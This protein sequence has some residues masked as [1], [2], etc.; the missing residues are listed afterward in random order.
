MAVIDS[1]YQYYLSTYANTAAC[2]YD[3]HKKSQLRDI[4]NQII[5][6]NKDSPLYKIENTK[7]VT[8]YAIDIKESV[9][10]LQNV[11][12]SLSDTNEG[13]ETI[14]S[15]RIAQSSDENMVSVEY[16]GE[17]AENANGFKIQVE[18]LASNQVNCGNYLNPERLDME[19]G[20]YSFH[21]NTASNCY[22]FQYT[23]TDSD[24]NLSILQKLAKL[25]HSA[26]ID[27]TAAINRNESGQTALTLASKQT[28]AGE[29]QAHIFEILPTPDTASIKA[30]E[31]LGIQSVTRKAQN[32]RFLL[33]GKEH[34]SF[35]NT[36]TVDNNF[37]I[38]LHACSED[39]KSIEIGFKT[40]ID[41]IADNLQK[42]A[43]TYNHI[44]D[45]A[46]THNS[47]KSSAKLIRDIGSAVRSYYNELESIGVIM[48]ADF[49]LSIDRS[50]LADAVSSEDAAECF[51]V[52]NRFKNTLFERTA[53]AYIDPMHY[54][55]K[56]VVAYKNPG[57]N[58]AAPYIT[59]I[60]SGIMLDW[61]C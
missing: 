54:V 45:V 36:F 46:N 44:I 30:M 58:F 10:Q 42:L 35:S 24:T 23:V 29:A 55:N 17:D 21:L 25:V 41:A 20:N 61:Y 52:L 53:T 59:S 51:D 27:I 18:Q 57:H 3:A 32:S 37:D 40:N 14:F 50:L 56:L 6:I 12:S 60:Y 5:K 9:R 11:I 34:S 26:G 43:D 7:D 47:G 22:E 15:K 16:I 19:P 13:I 8:K 33:N 39:G 49:H 31:V 4:C 48:D 38:T 1:A 2:R 28:G